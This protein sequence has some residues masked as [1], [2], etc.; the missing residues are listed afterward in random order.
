MTD[1]EFARLGSFIGQYYGVRYTAVKKSIL[2]NRLL[3]RLHYY[4]YASYS[5]YCD[6]VMDSS[7]N[8]EELVEMINLV[9]TNKTDFFRE[10][11]HFAFLR[12]QVLP[13]FTALAEHRTLKV[14]SSCCSSGEEIYTLAMV[15]Q[16]Y[17][18]E[19]G[20]ALPYQLLGTD[21]S[22]KV[23]EQAYKGVYD[24]S[25]IEKISLELKKKYFLL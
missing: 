21:I 25:R 10:S 8:K 11:G 9:T 13:A 6:L 15:L 7:H 4:G 24:I 19:Q 22:T 12:D 20:V 16:E 18:A 23:L 1:A 5:Q 3:K 2:E 17:A 14:W